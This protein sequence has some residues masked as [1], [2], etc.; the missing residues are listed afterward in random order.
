MFHSGKTK[1]KIRWKDTSGDS[2]TS[3]MWFYVVPGLHVP[4][5]LSHQF[6]EN[7]P[8]VWTVAEHGNAVLERIA[9][10]GFSRR[11]RKKKQDDAQFLHDRVEENKRN[12]QEA[13]LRQLE[14]MKERFNKNSEVTATSS[15][16]RISQSTG[17]E[18]GTYSSS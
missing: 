4:A 12:D 6:I 13:T 15:T 7:H 2:K 5:I 17:N 1:L 8:E 14:E 11:D 10:I 3:K 18:S 9:T 16:S